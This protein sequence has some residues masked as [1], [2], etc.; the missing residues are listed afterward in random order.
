VRFEYEVASPTKVNVLFGTLC[1][2]Q[3]AV[4]VWRTQGR[5]SVLPTPRLALGR[6]R[7]RMNALTDGQMGGRTEGQTG[8]D[9]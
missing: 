7:T 6:Q 3:G 4:Q 2:Y 5:T 1:N 9:V 8:R